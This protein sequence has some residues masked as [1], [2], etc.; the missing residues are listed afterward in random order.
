MHR[1]CPRAA[2]AGSN[3]RRLHAVFRVLI[4]SYYRACLTRGSLRNLA[5]QVCKRPEKRRL[6]ML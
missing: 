6:L 4:E 1:R 2:V 3:G 5:V